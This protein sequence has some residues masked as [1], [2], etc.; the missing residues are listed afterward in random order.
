MALA[1]GTV[2]DAKYRVVRT[3]AEGSAGAVYLAEHTLQKDVCALKLLTAQATADPELTSRFEREARLAARIDHENV[4]AVLGFGRTAYG[5][6]FL[7]TRFHEGRS[8]AEELAHKP[9][10]L[11]DRAVALAL[12]V[13]A[14]VEAVHERGVIHR[15]IKPSNVLLVNR[16]DGGE[17]AMLLDTGLTRLGPGGPARVTDRRLDL[18]EV[19]A[20]LFQMIVGRPAFEGSSTYVPPYLQSTPVLQS[21]A[22]GVDRGLSAI[23][24][25]ML[26]ADPAA[27]F[28]SVRPLR[29]QLAEYLATPRAL[30]DR[31]EDKL[32]ARARP[33][34]AGTGA[35]QATRPGNAAPPA[36]PSPPNRAAP[37]AAA[38]RR[39]PSPPEPTAEEARADAHAQSHSASRVRQLAPELHN[40]PRRP[41]VELRFTS[42]EIFKLVYAREI[43][44]GTLS[45]E[46]GGLP[47]VGAHLLVALLLPGGFVVELEAQVR[48]I[49]EPQGKPPAGQPART[50]VVVT[51]ERFD[52]EKRAQF[53]RI[54]AGGVMATVSNA[55]AAAQD[56]EAAGASPETPSPQGSATPEPPAAPDGLPSDAARAEAPPQVDPV[57]GTDLARMVHRAERTVGVAPVTG[58]GGRLRVRRVVVVAAIFALFMGG[59]FAWAV[60]PARDTTTDVSDVA[61]ILQLADGKRQRRTL[62][63]RISDPRWGGWSREEREKVARSLF[64]RVAEKGLNV[65]LLTD[66]AGHTLAL[67]TNID[68]AAQVQIF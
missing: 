17:Q 6:A 66:G 35:P 40:A 15:S 48:T 31:I 7:A 33:A 20:L 51:L 30:R 37:T 10:L 39:T 4:A 59:L 26:A 9:R 11:P 28:P 21:V 24:G 52:D 18:H 22:P 46:L 64:T 13:L 65:L 43:G 63:A 1:P 44:K 16:P 55:A 32:G 68:G 3:L 34:A 19:G 49:G 41:R 14:G 36:T 2:I 38:P 54:M 42:W 62:I 27:R 8:L 50:P 45:C 67:A 23:V 56:R 53:E 60:T 12:Q 47:T 5:E 29:E 57:G 25:K 58:Q 61:P